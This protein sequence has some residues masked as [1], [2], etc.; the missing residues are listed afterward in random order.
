MYYIGLCDDNLADLKKAEELLENYRLERPD[1]KFV[2]K[3][4]NAINDL[5][6]EI[7]K[8]PGFDMLILDIFMPEMTGIDASRTLRKQGVNCPVI[9]L[10]SSLDH[11]LDA[12]GVDAVQY[13]IKPAEQ[14][15]FFTALDKSFKL[16]EHMR[17]RYITLR[18]EGEL[19][20]I[21]LNDIIC[22][23]SHGNY[24]YISLVDGSDL[25][26]RITLAEL[27]TLMNDS[28]D[29]VRTGSAYLV[30]LVHVE[31][32]NAKQILLDNGRRIGVP[33]GAYSN[34]RNQYFKFYCER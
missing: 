26:V 21:S 19:R 22:C 30:N 34:L 9:F 23:E 29:F 32:M 28:H 6:A 1:V 13:L 17:R 25:R 33:R 15:Q 4:F 2:V 20:R 5:L 12:F 8:D 24:Q 27:H 7:D 18:V 16:I 14:S 3:P 31:S 10:T 11:A